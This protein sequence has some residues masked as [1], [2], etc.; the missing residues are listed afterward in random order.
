MFLSDGRKLALRRKELESLRPSGQRAPA[1][2]V[3][4]VEGSTRRGENIYN[5]GG[6]EVRF[7]AERGL[8][9]LNIMSIDRDRAT[10]HSKILCLFLAM[11]C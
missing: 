8:T 4:K 9:F 2:N 5:T 11:V 3:L 1:K 10:K 7:W 6:H